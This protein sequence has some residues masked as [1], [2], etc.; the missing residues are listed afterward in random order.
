MND[1]DFRY[2]LGIDNVT[3]VN[4]LLPT[5]KG[6]F[7]QKA[8]NVDIN[9]DGELLRRQGFQIAY[10]GS[11]THSFWANE[12][13]N[14]ALFVEGG[15]LKKLNLDMTVTTLLPYVGDSRMEYVEVN[16]IVYFSNE[17]VVG[18]IKDGQVSPFST[19]TEKFKVKMKGGQVIEYYKARLYAA[20]DNVIRYSDVLDLTR[21]D[22]RSDFIQ[23]EDRV[24]ML[25]AVKGGLY[26]GTRQ[27][28]HF[29]LGDDPVESKFVN[30]KLLDVGAY[31]GSAIKVIDDWG[32]GAEEHAVIFG[33]GYGVY[34]GRE[35]GLLTQLTPRYSISVDTG[36]IARATAILRDDRGFDQYLM[37]AEIS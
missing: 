14:L 30:A 35:E 20:R 13:G 37:V 32:R 10:G 26:V 24:T 25:K 18:F 33:T 1:L 19:P 6:Y 17:Q 28:V 23:M 27:K 5:R 9:D 11:G 22:E 36:V 8:K 15:T 3:P 29:F 16:K 21:M 2:C 12:E 7:V 31:E 34:L 4:K